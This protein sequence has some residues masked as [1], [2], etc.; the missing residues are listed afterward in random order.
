M[1]KY[2]NP[3]MTKGLNPILLCRAGI[4]LEIDPVASCRVRAPGGAGFAGCDGFFVFISVR[5]HQLR[6]RV[7]V[8]QDLREILP[9]RRQRFGAPLTHP[10]S[11]TKA[12]AI[13]KRDRI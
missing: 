13:V 8:F 7:C 9:R 6:L 4:T 5:S 1:S 2:V 3:A 11:V 12:V 10:H